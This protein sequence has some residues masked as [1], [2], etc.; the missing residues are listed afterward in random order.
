MLVLDP[1]IA[2]GNTAIAAL[3]LIEAWGL[4]MSNVQLL[5]IIASAASIQRILAMYPD[6]HV[7][8]M[9]SS[10]LT[11]QIVVAAIDDTLTEKGYVV[12]GCGDVGDRLYR[13]A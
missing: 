1:M 6:V 7:S 9:I 4:D 3:G 12:P 2:T 11:A 8:Q 5:S 13:S 10:L